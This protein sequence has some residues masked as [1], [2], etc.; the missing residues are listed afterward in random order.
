[1]S[2]LTIPRS[3]RAD[4]EPLPAAVGADSKT[5]D[6]AWVRPALASLLIATGV[7]YIWNLAASGWAN[8]FYSAAVQAGSVNW[9]AFFFG[10]SDAANA[11]TVDKPPAS[12]WIMALSVRMFGLS[13]W[14][15]LV[16]QALMGVAAVG[17]VY[18]TL[19]RR[20]P[21]G[22]ALLG[23]AILAVTPVATLM[24]R[25]NN[26]DA[27]LV[28]LMTIAGYAVVRAIDTGRARWLIGTGVLLGFGFLTKQLQAFVVIPGFALTYLI[29]APHPLLRRIRHT[30][31]AGLAMMLAA[32]WW[33]AIVELTP[34]RYRPYIGGSQRNSI[35]ELT[36]GYNGLG[37]LTGNETGSVTGGGGGGRWGATGWTRLFD[38]EIGGQITWLI[39]S[40]LILLSAGLVVA[41]R[42]RTDVA[43]AQLLMW[44]T[45]LIVTGLTFSFM[46]GI[47][48]AYYT[49]ALAP[50]V[51]GSV[52][53]GAGLL[54]ER[55]H[56]I[57]ARAVL[58]VAT[59]V[60]GYWSWTLLQ[61]TP[62]FQSWLG[63]TVL[64]GSLLA[65]AGLLVGSWAPRWIAGAATAAAI[66]AGLAGP[67][68]YSVQTVTEGHSGSIV[69]AGP[70]IAGAGGPGGGSQGGGTQ[71]GGGQG[72]GPRPTGGFGGGQGGAGTRT[73]GGGQGG[74]G[75]LLSGSTPSDEL[76]A[77][78]D[79]DA[80]D[81]TWV[82][83][84]VG[85]NN[86]SGYQLATEDP[87]MSI[88]GFNGSDPA[89]TLEQFQ[90]YV[91]DGR[92]H[93]FIAGGGFGGSNGSSNVSAQIAAWVEQT[94]TAV[95]VD[96]V[97]LYDLT[98]SVNAG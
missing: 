22:I 75:G 53:A 24:F 14:S 36:F 89:P 57:E 82:A 4:S 94:F 93:Y 32:G 5:K 68:A 17:V 26:P 2:I 65:A 1:M 96:G 80:Q 39:P 16:P 6:P 43:R 20:F 49:V 31:L 47:F 15:I 92:I 29:C 27:L 54:W 18:A 63:P 73:P 85:S 97:T 86:A 52:A 10:S 70:S 42:V 12:L 9:E 50:A 3:A 41:R 55:R 87:V 23:G 77:L 67:A 88:G 56:R 79:A 83:A 81:Y 74:A 71:G 30:L 58:A 33:I 11:I 51:A 34:A 48:H 78:L 8:S 44:G 19:R 38:D 84:T 37:R 66:A 25:F 72:G 59:A 90:A 95:T 76:V 21:A 61:R 46:A 13:S 45:W 98:A 35:L 28:L 62:D 40:A 7:L 91:A 60:A 64:V 69:T